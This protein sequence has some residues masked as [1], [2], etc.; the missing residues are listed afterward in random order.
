M[1]LGSPGLS[2]CHCLYLIRVAYT[3]NPT[4]CRD[5]HTELTCTMPGLIKDL[6][7]IEKVVNSMGVYS[8]LGMVIKNTNTSKVIQ[9]SKEAAAE[10]YNLSGILNEEMRMFSLRRRKIQENITKLYG[11]VWGQ[12]YDNLKAEIYGVENFVK[13]SIC[14]LQCVCFPM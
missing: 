5:Q 11:L 1:V 3:W 8:D 13:K 9:K 12:C 4:V 10:A 14:I 2:G 6:P 7:T